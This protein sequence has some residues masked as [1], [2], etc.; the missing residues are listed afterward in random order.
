MAQLVLFR[1]AYLCGKISS[2]QRASRDVIFPPQLIEKGGVWPSI[3]CQS[4]PF[5]PLIKTSTDKR[6]RNKH[7]KSNWQLL[8]FFNCVRTFQFNHIL[9]MYIECK[10]HHASFFPLGGK[11]GTD[12]PVEGNQINLAKGRFQKKN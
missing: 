2:L 1:T 6:W 10:F 11:L 9:I 8:Y 3:K 12:G 5:C 4:C 7:K